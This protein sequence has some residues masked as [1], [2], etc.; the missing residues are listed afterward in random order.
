MIVTIRV[1]VVVCQIT[2][3][4][5]DGISE[6]D[7]GLEGG[8]RIVYKVRVVCIGGFP[9]LLSLLVLLNSKGCYDFETAST[10]VLS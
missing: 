6:H 2:G 8:G 5:S 10:L 1:L 3:K 9:F 4:D 7:E